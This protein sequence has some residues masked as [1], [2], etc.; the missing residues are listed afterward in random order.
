MQYRFQK[1]PWNSFLFHSFINKSA[2]CSVAQK[3]RCL[4]M[5]RVMLHPHVGVHTQAL[6]SQRCRSKCTVAD[7]VWMWGRC[8]SGWIHTC[9]QLNI[10]WV[11]VLPTAQHFRT[12]RKV[13]IDLICLCMC[14]CVVCICVCVS[15]WA[16]SLNPPAR[17]AAWCLA[18]IAPR[19]RVWWLL[20]WKLHVS[21]DGPSDW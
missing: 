7:P 11:G 17:A 14:V 15:V 20:A 13:A 4:H 18:E 19:C 3:Q 5:L 9:L 21:L 12:C 2:R 10:L 1:P 8:R 6:L 16:A